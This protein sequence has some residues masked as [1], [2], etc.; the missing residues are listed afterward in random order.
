MIRQ[1][2][3][4]ETGAEPDAQARRNRAAA[5]GLDVAR[6]GSA[7]FDRAGFSDPTLVLRWNEIV[8]PELARFAQPL[9]MTERPSGGILTLKADPAA[10]V[11]L[12]HESRALCSRINSYLGRPAVQR[13]RF[14]AGT[15]K[16]RLPKSHG[17]TKGDSAPEDSLSQFGGQE[18]LRSALLALAR[19]RRRNGPSAKD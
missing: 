4:P 7:G 15:V 11:F 5:V 8:G 10:S 13:L 6:L 12:Q 2:K 19:A 14:V 18:R 3:Q 16:P 9:R 17:P 1:R